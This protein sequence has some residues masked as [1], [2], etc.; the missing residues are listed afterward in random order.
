MCEA[1][2]VSLKAAA[3]QFPL[4]HSTH[5]SVIPGAQTQNELDENIKVYSEIIP[6]SFWLDLKSEKLL[7]SDAPIG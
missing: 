4:H 7:R 2:S 1:H 3:L 5:L 6:S